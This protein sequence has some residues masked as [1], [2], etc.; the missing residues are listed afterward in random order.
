MKN[1]KGIFW[2]IIFVFLFFLTQD[3][4]FMDWGK[5]ISWLGFPKWLAWFAFV[6]LLF[7]GVFYIFSK[8]YWKE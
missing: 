4:F 5:G 8:K 7:I 6:H 1:K 2:F 3:Y